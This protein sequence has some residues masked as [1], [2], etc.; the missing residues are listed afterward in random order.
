MT[1]SYNILFIIFIHCFLKLLN[2]NTSIPFQ[3][4]YSWKLNGSFCT[5]KRSPYYTFRL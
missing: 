1:I 5:V 2:L 3:N 4:D